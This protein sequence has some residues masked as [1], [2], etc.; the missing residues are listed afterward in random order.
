MPYTTEAPG[1]LRVVAPNPSVYTGAGTNSYLIRGGDGAGAVVD[2]GSDDEAYLSE[3]EALAGGSGGVEVI[4][5][6][7]QHP[8][9]VGG[10]VRLRERTGARV[11]AS[12]HAD[13]DLVDIR[14]DDG[15]I[16]RIGGRAVRALYTPGHRFDHLCYDVDDTGV[17]MAGDLVAGEGTV[18][19]APPEGD[20]RDYLTS[21]HRLLDMTIALLL[22][23]HGPPISD[24]RDRL[25]QY[26]AHREE[27]ERQVLAGIRAGAVTSSDLVDRVYP[28]LDSGLRSA[29]T[30]T[31]E[32][33]LQK[34]HRD[35][36]IRP[37]DGDA[38]TWRP[39][40]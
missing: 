7:H 40:T 20:L 10:V 34:L 16:V 31:I 23:G 17:V 38:Q 28:D 9:H 18:L 37:A 4:L 15:D 1:I 30:L 27:R 5:V 29:A 26:V 32:A 19:I 36:A 21:L 25:L 24:A 22:P 2:P 11:Y 14:L 8:D 3:L 12:I 39:V 13:Q 6:T 33:H 35:G